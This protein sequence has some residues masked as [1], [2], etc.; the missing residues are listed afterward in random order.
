MSKNLLDIT[1]RNYIQS[2][3][4]DIESFLWV[5]LW[6]TL[7]NN[8]VEDSDKMQ[9]WMSDFENGKRGDTLDSYRK[10]VY[11][12]DAMRSLID[13]WATFSK[14][15]T[16]RYELTIE[17]FTRICNKNGWESEEEEARYWKAAWHGYALEGVCKSLE[18]I[19]RNIVDMSE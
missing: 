17:C 14:D 6:A 10:P 7:A 8:A 2:P 15:L 9:A 5:T 13:D 4:D 18:I 1:Q 11:D 12:D 16:V 19:F 3:V